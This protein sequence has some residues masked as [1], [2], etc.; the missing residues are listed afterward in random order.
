M[1]RVCSKDTCPVGIATQNEK[2]RCRFKGKPEHVVC[3]MTFIAGQLRQIMAD[4]GFARLE[5]MIGRTDC[6]RV[7]ENLITDR[8]FKVDMRQ[9]LGDSP[10]PVSPQKDLY[11]FR[12]ETTPDLSVLVPAFAEGLE[13]GAMEGRLP[14]SILENK[15]ETDS[16]KNSRRDAF[17]AYLQEKK[18]ALGRLACEKAGTRVIG[19]YETSLQVSSTD[20]AFGAILG[21][22]VT[23]NCGNTLADDT[24]VVNACGGGGQSFGAFLPKGVT[25]RLTGD[26][27]D[28]FGKGLSG[29]KL[30]VVPDKDSPFEADKNI[31]VGN[32][33]LFG[34]TSGKAYFNGIAGER[35]GVR[36]SGATIVA[37]GCG[38]HG[39]EYMTGGRAVILG[40]TGKNFAAGMSGGIAYV[41]D[42]DHTLYRRMNKDMTMLQ[43][44]TE[45]YDIA[46]LRGILEDYVRETSSALGQKI[47]SSYTDYL[48]YFKKIVPR[49]YQ[50]M[51]TAISR[52]EE[53]GMPHDK[54]VLEAFREISAG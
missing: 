14:E 46:E 47:L 52:H 28:G 43:E 6:L 21:S 26:A 38:D 33:A 37:E 53:Q 45:D 1:M 44:L 25:I 3:F 20:R 40:G 17:A 5:D 36:N 4:L 2:L 29:G 54:A 24:F 51:L 50:R 31:I 10:F 34:A 32:V 18:K 30:I 19:H 13:K 15:A 42:L 16:E 35:F 9:I 12:L 49:D 41:L 48:S 22:E 11:D 27:N 39:L 8:A 7:R 23:K